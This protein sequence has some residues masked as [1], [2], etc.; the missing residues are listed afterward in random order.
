MVEEKSGAGGLD[1]KV[2]TQISDSLEKI[3]SR[4]SV[5]EP[6]LKAIGDR[7][8]V[9]EGAVDV[10]RDMIRK[11]EQVEPDWEPLP[12]DKYPAVILKEIENGTM[13]WHRVT[14][15]R[16]LEH[17]ITINGFTVP[18]RKGV[19][20]EIPTPWFDDAIARGEAHEDPI[21]G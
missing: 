5:I 18:F 8:D 1:E 6:T 2:V 3:M 21:I 17:G 4:L 7:V 9:M 10:L 16:T 14:P 15:L 19:T 20:M 13:E 11:R 12:R